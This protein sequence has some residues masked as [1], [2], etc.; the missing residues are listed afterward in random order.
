MSWLRRML[1]P[2]RRSFKAPPDESTRSELEREKAARK[3]EHDR[4]E[5]L[6]QV[7]ADYRRQD[8]MLRR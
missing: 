2:M 8:R 1:D 7:I 6:A 5:K 3:T 4:T